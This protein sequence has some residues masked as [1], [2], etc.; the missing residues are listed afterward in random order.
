MRADAERACDLGTGRPSGHVFFMHRGGG[1]V[2]LIRKVISACSHVHPPD[3]RHPGEE[4]PPPLHPGHLCPSPRRV[5]FMT[6]PDWAPPA[7]PTDEEERVI[8]PIPPEVTARPAG[9]DEIPNSARAFTPYATSVTYARGYPDGDAVT[10]AT[11]LMCG[12]TVALKLDGCLRVH[13]IPGSRCNSTIMTP[14]GNACGVCAAPVKRLKSGQPAAHRYP[15][16]RCLGTSHVAGSEHVPS[17][18]SIVVRGRWW[19]GVWENGKFGVAYVVADGRSRRLTKI[20]ELKKW[21]Q[22]NG[23]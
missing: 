8:S 4:C 17:V 7:R 15:T 12:Q 21:V 9:A 6:D 2:G 23:Q 18:E 10:C 19:V 11:C 5:E 3:C 13:S 14:D 16:I 20:T 22:E 1:T